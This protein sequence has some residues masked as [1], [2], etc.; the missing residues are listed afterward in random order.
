MTTV[1][2][3]ALAATVSV[4]LDHARPDSRRAD[5][6]YELGAAFDAAKPTV[7][8]VTDGQQF[9]VTP[10]RVAA[11]Q[12]DL[13][14][15]AFNV[16][17]TY[18]RGATEA[19]Q[20]AAM[21]EDGSV[22]WAR[23][24]TIFRAEQWVEDLDA[25]RRAVVGREGKVVVFGTSGGALLAHQYLARY[26]RHVTRAFTSATVD[27]WVVAQLGLTTDRFWSEISGQDRERVS[28]A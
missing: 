28:R 15:D 20:R 10:G 6:G 3:L 1:V 2:L 11:I 5:L 19:F 4:P 9:R 16:V 17:A 26:G 24:W 12:K 23:A 25:V 22:D 14:G 13:F 8:Y 18:G 21:R 7:L 27:P